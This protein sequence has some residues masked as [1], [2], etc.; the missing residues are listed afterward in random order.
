MMP[1][2]ALTEYGWE[3][4]RVIRFYTTDSG[5]CSLNLIDSAVEADIFLCRL[6]LVC[7]AILNFRISSCMSSYVFTSIH[8]PF[9]LDKPSPCQKPHF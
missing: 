3:D 1:S 7:S 6:S 4:V 5:D 9:L 8:I 2:A